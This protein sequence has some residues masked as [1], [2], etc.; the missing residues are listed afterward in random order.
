M[1]EEVNSLILKQKYEEAMQ[2]A[3]TLDWGHVQSVRILCR[4]SDLYKYEKRYQ[5]SRDILEYAYRRCPRNRQILYSMCELELKLGNYIRALQL[6]NAYIN[7]APTDSGR[8]VLKY[9][10][11][12]EQNVNLSEQIAVLEELARHDFLERWSYELA[13]LYHKA[14]RDGDCVDMCDE[15]A[16]FFGDGRYVDK[17]LA[18]RKSVLRLEDGTAKSHSQLSDTQKDQSDTRKIPANTQKAQSDTR[19]IPADTQKAQSDTQKAQSDTQKVQ[20]D[21]PQLQQTA[22]W[23]QESVRT[24]AE[25]GGATGIWSS[26]AVRRAQEENRREYNIPQENREPRQENQELQRESQEPQPE[27][28]DYEVKIDDSLFSDEQLTETVA[29][30]MRDLYDSEKTAAPDAEDADDRAASEF[31]TTRSWNLQEIREAEEKQE[32]E[33]GH[34]AAVREDTN[35][36]DPDEPEPPGDEELI[37]YAQEYAGKQGYQIDSSGLEALEERIAQMR[38]KGYQVVPE[39]IRDM[40]GEA[41]YYSGIGLYGTGTFSNTKHGNR[42]DMVLRDK[43]FIH[44]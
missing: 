12:R 9:K 32:Q 44:Y 40:I 7:V 31:S 13:R 1:A 17:A 34:S 6:Y 43:D 25:S 22:R 41:I 11:Y 23:T 30:G 2:L 35:G 3:D 37:T 14:G 26:D 27:Q 42:G 39:D 4:V 10:L 20:S 19:Q 29:K 21:M 18:L 33:S 5:D 28:K 36:I 16:A 24:A 38:G 15:I 8:Y